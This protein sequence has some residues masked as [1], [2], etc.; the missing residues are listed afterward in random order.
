MQTRWFGIPILD[1]AQSTTTRQTVFS[2]Y[3]HLIIFKYL[4][5]GN[6]NYVYLTRNLYVSA[7]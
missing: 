1:K 4:T 7:V 5:F 6:A 2:L 3:H